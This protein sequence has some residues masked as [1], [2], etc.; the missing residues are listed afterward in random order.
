MRQLLVGTQLLVLRKS[1]HSRIFFEDG[2][3]TLL[4]LSP[5]MSRAFIAGL[6]A[7]QRSK[8]LNQDLN[9]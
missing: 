4:C 7:F 6:E 1:G 5:M 9:T 2:V 3:K 8:I